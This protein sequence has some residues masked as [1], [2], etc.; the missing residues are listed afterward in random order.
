LFVGLDRE[1]KGPLDA[2]KV[3]NEAARVNTNLEFHIAG[4][5]RYRRHAEQSLHAAGV[6]GRAVF[7][8]YISFEKYRD[9]LAVS[10]IVLVPS[11]HAADG[12]SEGGAPVVCI[13]AQA[14]GKPVVGTRHCDIPFVVRDGESGLLSNEGDTAS[15]TR[16]LLRLA[17]DA[18]ERRRMG[19]RGRLHAAQQHDAAVQAEVLA[20]MYRSVL[21]DTAPGDTRYD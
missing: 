8:G 15:M 3:F 7:H 10:D 18:G 4:D 5:G 1:K 21:R 6:R 13:E 2:V 17:A 19:E 16:D 14:A 20:G 12:D 9:I 11:R